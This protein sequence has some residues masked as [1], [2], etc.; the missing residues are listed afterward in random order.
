MIFLKFLLFGLV[1]GVTT[2]I[3][4]G[5]GSSFI[6]DLFGDNK[7]NKRST[8]SVPKVNEVLGLSQDSKLQDSKKYLPNKIEEVIAPLVQASSNFQRSIDEI[9]NLPEN[10][11]N[12]LKSQICKPQ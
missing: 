4:I 8:G 3:I 7:S 1:L 10:E 5:P 9:K 2:F 6:Y 12:A 11:L